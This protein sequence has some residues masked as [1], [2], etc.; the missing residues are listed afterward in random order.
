M[1]KSILLCLIITSIISCQSGKQ[2]DLSGV[3]TY[4]NIEK[5]IAE[6]SSD[7]YLGRM[8]M[9]STEPAV[10][11]YI[12]SQMKE[13]GLEPANQGSFFQEVPIL[14]VTSKISPYLIFKTPDGNLEVP[15]MT[16]YVSFTRK[17]EE[18]L[19]L[20][21][22]EVIFAGFGITAPEYNRNDFD[23][24]DVKGKTILVFINDPGYGTE[25][26]YFKGNTM[27]YYGRWTYK[28]EEA[29]RQGA[30]ACFIIHETGPAG[31]GWNVVSNNGETT[32]LY[33][34]PEDGYQNRC[35]FEG[36]ISYSSAAQL[37]ARCGLDI[38]E[39]KKQSVS[40][41][42]KPFSLPVTV[43]ATIKNQFE[44]GISRNVCGVI[45]GKTRPDEA[46]VYTA[47]WDHLGVGKA[48]RGD[49][50][51]N[52]ATDNASAISWM[53][54]I[55]RAF[56]AA[57]QTE[58]SVLFISPTGEESGLLGAV[59]YCEHPFFRLDKTVACI[60]T[61]VLLFA[62]EFNDVTL[63]GSGYS[64]LD[65]WVEAEAK[66][67]GRYIANDPNPENGMFFRSDHFPFVKRG[68]PAIFAKGYSD[69]KK[70]GPVK[71]KELIAEYWKNIYHTPGDE[72]KPERD[73]LS[74]LVKDAYLMY[75]VGY[76]L[77]N[78]AVFPAWKEGSE[79]RR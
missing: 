24:V 61:D 52:G 58:R 31:Y 15:K 9:S 25:G 70:L 67:Q 66:R 50:I 26:P 20:E 40:P 47:H 22:S 21:N 72:Y 76:R 74:G 71:T 44:T 28:F 5:H 37:F 75:N 2:K 33:L 17:M 34:Q 48:I 11:E 45:K 1:K 60:N 19:S 35:S 16:D 7:K 53:L 6:L 39:V 12:A 57:P 77:A 51:Y 10:V 14:K 59:Y 79:F 56:K 18:V 3:I 38:E 73:D 42:F 65:Q 49:S 23:G 32:K 8:P 36:W 62:G 55:A 69:A 41:A 29:A 4:T 27:T 63:T 68:V 54:E 64:G 30:K 43:S 13:I 46:V 78:S